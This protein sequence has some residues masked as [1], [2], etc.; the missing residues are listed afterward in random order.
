[1]KGKENAYVLG[2]TGNTGSGKSSV[3][4]MLKELGAQVLDADAMAKELQEPGQPGYRAI[5]GA[6]GPDFLLEDGRLDRKKLAREV[7]SHED[8]LKK[9]NGMIHPLVMD[10]IIGEISS[11]GGLVVLD[12][13]LLFETGMDRLC[14]EI[15]LV[16]AREEVRLARIMA[17]DCLSPTEARMRMANQR[18][19]DPGRVHRV[20]DNSGNLADLRAQV[21]GWYQTMIKEI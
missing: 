17:R 6:F 18:E 9:L 1:M 2:I 5:L 21:A 3:C 16:T 11:H 13:P 7:F 8:S 10:A 20:L 4:G 12:V 19:V 14:H 15:W